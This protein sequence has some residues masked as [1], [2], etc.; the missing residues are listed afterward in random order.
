MKYRHNITKKGVLSNSHVRDCCRRLL[1]AVAEWSR[2]G[3]HEVTEGLVLSNEAEGQDIAELHVGGGRAVQESGGALDDVLTLGWATT[4]PVTAT[5]DT[6]L[7]VAEEALHERLE[8]A[9][10]RLAEDELGD[11]GVGVVA[12]REEVAQVTDKAA[13]VVVELV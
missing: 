3:V 12:L 11:V 4:D 1:V 13:R 9:D 10:L 2:H 5:V 6:E 7:V 8:V